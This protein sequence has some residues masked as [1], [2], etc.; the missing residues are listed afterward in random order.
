M[1][2]SM[3]Y[4]VATRRLTG[5]KSPISWLMLTLPPNKLRRRPWYVFFSSP[6]LRHVAGVT[7]QKDDHLMMLLGF[8]IIS[9]QLKKGQ[10]LVAAS[11]KLIAETTAKLEQAL[12]KQTTRDSLVED[13][14][15]KHPKIKEEVLNEINNHE[16]FKDM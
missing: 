2:I 8:R 11:E 5:V 4:R 1:V 15:A 10:E 16:W 9:L 13:V 6:F 12:A 7:P 14:W 3:V